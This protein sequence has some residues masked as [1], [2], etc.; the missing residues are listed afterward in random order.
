[1]ALVPSVPLQRL[2]WTPVAVLD[3]NGRSM[4]DAARLR[5][6][7]VRF[8]DNRAD[9][10]SVCR[11]YVADSLRSGLALTVF[12][13]DGAKAPC[14]KKLQK[15]QDVSQQGV[16]D[17]FLKGLE[18]TS[19]AALRGDELELLDAA[20]TPIMR[21]HPQ[22][23]F[24]GVTWELVLMDK[25]P[26]SKKEKL[27][28]PDVAV[29]EPITATFETIGV[30]QGSTGKNR[31]LADYDTRRAATIDITDL[32]IEGRKCRGKVRSA[33]PRCEQE[34]AFIKLLESADGFYVAPEGLSLLHGSRKI[35]E[36]RPLGQAAPPTS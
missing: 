31:Y 29:D 28:P 26:N 7:A 18:A 12:N 21:L 20:G 30:V 33:F 24:V 6:S 34:A 8:I 15:G 22:P 5:T 23:E 17:L 1:M 4:V 27:R 10:R 9:G 2:T 19:A 11:S 32:A 25:A 13:I 36:F 14:R 35:L 16:E 3:Q